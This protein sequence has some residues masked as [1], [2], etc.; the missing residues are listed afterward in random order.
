[1]VTALSGSGPAYF[2]LVMEAI[3]DA[4]VHMGLPRRMARQLVIETMYGASQ[5]AR[6][7]GDHPAYLREN[8]TSPGGTTAAALFACEEGG[9]RTVLQKAVWAAYRCVYLL[10][11]ESSRAFAKICTHLASPLA[12][13]YSRSLEVGGRDSNVGPGRAQPSAQPIELSE[14]MVKE[15]AEQ[16]K[17]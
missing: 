5:L 7:S 8:I 15:L 14:D 16:I 6:E 9:L 4:G 11:R 1:M 17:E 2:M 13:T 3:T 10:G 12:P